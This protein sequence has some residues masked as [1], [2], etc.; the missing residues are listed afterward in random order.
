MVLLLAAVLIASLGATASAQKA[1]VST[2][3]PQW[4][5]PLIPTLTLPTSRVGAVSFFNGSGIVIT[6]GATSM[7]GVL[8]AP[9]F[10]PT[11]K[12]RARL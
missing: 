2:K 1:V 12:L 6:G 3:V 4:L 9:S 11:G 5:V 7:T 10:F 8:A